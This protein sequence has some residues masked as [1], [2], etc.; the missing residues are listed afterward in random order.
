MEHL[1]IVTCLPYLGFILSKDRLKMDPAKDQIIQVWPEPR[2]VKD[3]QSFLGFANFY[4]RFISNYSDI[5]VLL[6]WLTRKG[7]PWNFS[8][9][10]Q[11]SFNFLKSTFTTA[12]ILTHWIPNKQLIIETDASDYALGAILSVVVDSSEV[13]PFLFIPAHFPH[14]NSIT[15]ELNSSIMMNTTW[16]IVSKDYKRDGI[17]DLQYDHYF[18]SGNDSLLNKSSFLSFLKIRS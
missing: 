14:P 8:D 4:R 13:H 2:K 18:A 10:A 6:T 7:L 11:N 3:I 16:I 9:A 1:E 12:P 15:T 5:V 17:K